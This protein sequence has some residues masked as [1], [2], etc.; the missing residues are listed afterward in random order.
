[1][2][3]NYKTNE[4]VE[5]RELAPSLILY[6]LYTPDIAN[7]VHAGQFVVL[8][9][10]DYAER[11]PL[12]VAE[13]DREKGLIT[14]IIQVVGVGTRKLG[15]FK[16]GDVILDVVGPLGHKSEIK[17]F[18]TVVCIG[19]G[20]G[21]APVLPIAK[22][23]Y[24]A[25]N[26]I[27]SIIGARN[28]EMLILEDEMNANSNQL[29][30][31]TDDGS[32]GHHGFVTDVLKKLIVEDKVKINRV[33]AIG[34]VVMMKA[35]SDVTR[36]YNLET[37]VSLNSIMVDGT[38]MCGGCRASIGGETKFVCVDGPEFDA[39]KVDFKELT[40]RQQMYER[41]EH[42]ALWDHQC[43]I[44]Q[45]AEELK[46]SKTREPM[47]LQDPK[48]RIQN[49]NEVAL[50]YSREQARREAARCLQCKKQPCVAGCPVNIDIPGFIKKIKDG[51]FMGAIHRIKE[52]NS[53]PAV[54]GR[55]CPQEEQCEIVC[56]LEKKGQ[57]I[58][59]GRLERFAADY[60]FEQGE[61][62]VPKPPASTGKKVAVIG[63]GP[64]GL[65]VAGDLAKKGHKVTIFE[66]LHKAGGVLVYGIPEFRLPKSIV[67][68]E[69]DYVRKL[70]VEIKENTIIGQTKNMDDLLKEGFD[71]VFIGTGAG[72][73]YFLGIPGENLN[74]IYSA[75]EFLTR[76]NLMK[77]YLF[78]EYDTPVRLA[79]RVAIIGGGN[80]AMDGARVAKRL[81]SEHVYLVY[82]RSR[83][84]LPAREEE[85]EHAEEEGIEFHLLNNPVRF[86]GD[87]NG[88]LKGM[89]CIKMELGEPDDSGRRRPV[90]VPGSEFILDCEVAVV[91]IG[92]G[93][94]PLLTQSMPDLE[95]TKWGN[96]KANEEDG[97]TSVKGVFAGGDIVTG[98][99]TVILAMGAG[100]KA[101]AAMDKYLQDGIW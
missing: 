45:A 73:P 26:N 38:G 50:G 11:I 76:N 74:G 28:H 62:T 8:R 46:K 98:A 34:P 5:K 35:V 17:N 39:H 54:C 63:A 96:I 31:T 61:I 77:S 93:A 78:P 33:I 71:A 29:Y 40:M 97:K 6:K 22:A 16:Q 92:Q 59:I 23:L 41:E 85:V 49:F 30:A 81:G 53:L 75:N 84:E 66:A 52:T 88:W 68:T 3:N 44:D 79:D 82:R 24:E 100:R 42:R 67:Q 60:E 87:E 43:K 94:N 20:V 65:A 48:I 4:I 14:V 13:Y 57:P 70:G 55:V 101:A 25:G 91:A 19:G 86:I 37:I 18:G 27:I 89:E 1:M 12:T 56:V 64:A 95:L 69:I 72:L 2:N 36:E 90:P 7:K 9:A 15:A 83:T 51:D 32:Y 21:V 80:V 47:P 99:A 10:D 58:A